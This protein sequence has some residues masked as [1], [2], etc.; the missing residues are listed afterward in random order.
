M[1][2]LPS[3]EK[4]LLVD[5]PLNPEAARVQLQQARL[6]LDRYR[7]ALRLARG[8]IEHRNKAIRTLTAFS[9]QA[10]RL[11]NLEALWQL[12]LA[13]ALETTQTDAGAVVVIVPET[14]SL[15]LGVHKNLTPALARVLSGRQFDAG[16]AALMPHLVSGQGALLEY[17]VAA[18]EGEKFLLKSG[19]LNS[20]VSLPLQVGDQLRGALVVGA[21]KK[22]TF[23]PADL[24][25]LIALS[26]EAAVA[27]QSLYVQGQLWHMAETL[28][29]EKE[30][31]RPA[32]TEELDP[33]SS[34]SLPL[35]PLQAKLARLVAD[36]DGTMGALFVVEHSSAGM[37]V[38]LVADHGLSPAFTGPF[39]RFPLTEELFPFELLAERKLIVSDLSQA[40]VST[41]PRLLTRLREEG[42]TSLAVGQL[43]TSDQKLWLLLA[44]APRPGVLTTAKLRQLLTAGSDLP[45][46][47]DQASPAPPPPA[48]VVKES[49]PSLVPRSEADDLEKLLA[50][51]MEAEEEVQRHNADLAALN[52]ISEMINSTFN[53]DKI[54]K[55]VVSQTQSLLQT[56]AIWLY[57]VDTYSTEASRKRLL[58]QLHHGLSERYVRGMYRL[59]YGKYL[60]GIAVWENEAHFVSDVANYHVRC[61]LLVEQE[62]LQAIA[63]IP[64]SCPEEQDGRETRRVL[65]VMGVAMHQKHVW[66]PREVRLL[67][68]IANQVGLAINNAQLYSQ[69]KDG[70]TMLANSNQVLRIVNNQLLNDQAA[71]QARLADLEDFNEI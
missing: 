51:M 43:S 39:A 37:Q 65:G 61:H 23:S 56:D 19:Q 16:A 8:E 21:R 68:S 31:T 29:S 28:L 12:T 27:M 41:Q 14:G 3:K 40:N 13:R 45:A 18:E 9:Y 5:W 62:G 32:R 11:N 71:L 54:L 67:T 25:F 70:M 33:S 55:Q 20:L 15:S 10:G 38:T 53:L 26:Q 58:L 57:L 59:P 1:S 6:R 48:P 30:A 64:L 35:S 50:A 49:V 52:T 4:P 69:V 17:Q 34:P 42:A 2:K 44:A 36:I 7:A 63:A 47:Q 46:L 24:Y 66:Q 60:E 22:E